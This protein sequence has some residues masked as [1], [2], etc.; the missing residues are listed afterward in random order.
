MHWSQN[1]ETTG[2]WVGYCVD[3][4][5]EE[6]EEPSE[7]LNGAGGGSMPIHILQQRVSNFT[8]YDG[9]IQ[10]LGGYMGQAGLLVFDLNGNLVDK[11]VDEGNYTFHVFDINLEAGD[12]FI[13]PYQNQGNQ[14]FKWQGK[15]FTI[16]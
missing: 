13:I 7:P 4:E 3:N 11:Y 1:C 5:V 2:E 6:P 16:N 12:Y 14:I 15:E 8:Y 9:K 10:F